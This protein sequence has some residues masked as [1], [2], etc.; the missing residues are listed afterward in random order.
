MSA[1]QFGSATSIPGFTAEASLSKATRRFSRRGFFAPS[2]DQ[3]YPAQGV[4]PWPV[5][6][7]DLGDLDTEQSRTYGTITP[8]NEG[9]FVACV[10]TCRRNNPRATFSQCWSTCCRQYT[11]FQSCVIA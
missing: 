7:G 10:Q 5:D 9:N 6:I 4:T 2:P 11:G 8:V 3:A 1:C